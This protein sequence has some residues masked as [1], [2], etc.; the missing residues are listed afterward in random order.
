MIYIINLNLNTQEN[1]LINILRYQQ[2]W[3]MV[4]KNIKLKFN[5]KY[6]NL[7]KINLITVNKR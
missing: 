3:Y 2:E 6:P 4:Y 1:Q 5:L 7:I